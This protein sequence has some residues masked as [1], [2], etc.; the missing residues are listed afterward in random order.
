[1]ST[2]DDDSGAKNPQAGTP[3]PTPESVEEPATEP[4]SVTLQRK[5]LWAGA[6]L[7]ALWFIGSGVVGLLK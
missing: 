4:K 2:K 3:E 5:L 1:M 6:A 7:V